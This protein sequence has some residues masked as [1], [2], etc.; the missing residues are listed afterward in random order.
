VPSG[1]PLAARHMCAPLLGIQS[2]SHFA[3]RL[4]RIPSV[5]TAAGVDLA[6]RDM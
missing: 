2:H 1:N 4:E 6:E 5:D 3:L